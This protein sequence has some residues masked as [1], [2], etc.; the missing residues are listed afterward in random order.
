MKKKKVLTTRMLIVGFLAIF[1]VVLSLPAIVQE[2]VIAMP[3][4]LVYLIGFQSG[5]TWGCYSII[6][7]F[8]QKEKTNE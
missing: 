5:V 4:V 7:N 2:P 6:E 8:E 1:G 3:I